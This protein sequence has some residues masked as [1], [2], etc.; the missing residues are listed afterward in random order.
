MGLAFFFLA[1]NPQCLKVLRQELESAFPGPDCPL[2]AAKL[3]TLP[4]LEGVVNEALRLG[5]PY[6]LPRIVPSGGTHIDGKFIPEDTV[7]AVAAY[8]QQ[9]SPD[10]FYP[11]P[12]VGS[13]LHFFWELLVDT[14]S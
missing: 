2:P 3:A 10:N 12:L 5:T 6:F 1:A 8:S 13:Y 9:V 11:D 4:Y 14:L 7:V